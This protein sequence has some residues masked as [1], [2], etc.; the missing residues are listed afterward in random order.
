MTGS[1]TT[2]IAQAHSHLTAPEGLTALSKGIGPPCCHYRLRS[3][4]RAKALPRVRFAA[5]S[6]KTGRTLTA[7]LARPYSRQSAWF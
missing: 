6:E 1:S 5:E 2:R 7:P 4:T 3:S